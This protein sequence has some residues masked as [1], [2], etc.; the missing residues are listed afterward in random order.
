MPASAPHAELKPRTAWFTR[1]A[2]RPAVAPLV[3]LL[4]AVTMR[5]A[6]LCTGQSSLRSDEAVVGLM[7]KHIVT[8]G[9]RPLF[10]YGQHYGG[11]HAMVAYLAA[12]L[13]ALFGRSAVILTGITTAFSVVNI[14]LL[15][16]IVKRFF[17]GLIATAAAGIY[18]FSPPVVYQAFLVN[19]GTESFCLALLSLMYF[20][21]SYLEDTGAAAIR[22]AALA[23]VCAGL[24]Y[25]AMDYT[26]LYAVV[27]VLL[28]AATGRPGKWKCLGTFA[29]GFAA[30]CTPLV[31]YNLAHNFAHERQMFGG[32]YAAQVGF[33]AHVFGA[34]WHALTQGLAVFFSGEIDDYTRAPVGI[35]SWFHA[36]LAIVAVAALLFEQR[37][38][39]AQ[40]LKRFSLRG[41]E[42][43][44]L[45]AAVIPL[46][47]ILVYLAMYCAAGFSQPFR[48]TPRYFLPLCPFVSVAIAVFLLWR[49]R[50]WARKPAFA[51]VLVLMARGL[52]VSTAFGTRPWHEEHR[53][54]TRGNDIKML[55]RWLEHN[56]VRTVIAP[57]EIQWRLLFETDERVLAACDPVSPMP[58][59]AWYGRR[60]A[61]RIAAGSAC[62]LVFRNDLAFARLAARGPLRP[63][64]PLPLFGMDLDARL[65]Q[66]RAVILADRFVIY[67][68]VSPQALG[69]ML[70]RRLWN[71]LTR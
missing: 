20:L 28:W 54:R 41:R 62:A 57:Y 33:A 56:N 25:Y 61:R 12:P 55:A 26:L 14:I 9:E 4:L 43:S 63:G 40:S 39:I 31:L 5:G 2:Q 21:R 51:L 22:H 1:L 8:R 47:F 44:P 15:W 66:D 35:G 36:G 11:G 60:V 70:D 69:P 64:E 16:F 67:T 49:R 18:A 3:L 46:V 45:P 32:S 58:R 17:G 37:G 38:K 30:G 27:F 19:G 71:S 23:G 10:L 34:L 6:I 59:Y 48:R 7:A 42:T 53:I 50:G 68:P 13:F 52:F 24:A 29:L 65:L